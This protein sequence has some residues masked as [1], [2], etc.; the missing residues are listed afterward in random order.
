MKHITLKKP[1]YKGL[2]SLIL[3]VLV[4]AEYRFLWVD[5]GSS[6]ASSDAQIFGLSKLRKK[7]E[8]GDLGLPP[9]VVD[10]C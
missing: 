7:D 1:H 10:R 8:D 2:F 4:V 9:P 6:G 3:L 5:V